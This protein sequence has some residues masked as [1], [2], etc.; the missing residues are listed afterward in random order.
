MLENV[1]C[2]TISASAASMLEEVPTFANWWRV[3]FIGTI[4]KKETNNYFNLH[5]RGTFHA[6][7]MSSRHGKKRRRRQQQEECIGLPLPSSSSSIS[8]Q[9]DS[10]GRS[11]DRGAEDPSV[12]ENSNLLL[13]QY[14]GMVENLLLSSNQQD[15]Q[16]CLPDSIWD[17]WLWGTDALQECHM[18]VMMNRMH[19]LGLLIARY[20]CWH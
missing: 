7:G 11:V 12:S 16:C 5:A 2:S 17:E 18:D 14:N 19:L 1:A 10:S 3:L 8:T 4:N 9:L 15:E 13:S 20:T 6:H